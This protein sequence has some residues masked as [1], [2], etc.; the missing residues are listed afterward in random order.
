MRRPEPTVQLGHNWG[1]N[2][3]PTREYIKVDQTNKYYRGGRSTDSI[4]DQR[5]IPTTMSLYSNDREIG[6]KVIKNPYVK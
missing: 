5:G 1:I 2:A 3:I 4:S 6:P